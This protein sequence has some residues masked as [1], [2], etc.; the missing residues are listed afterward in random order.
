MGTGVVLALAA[1]AG[2]GGGGG[3]ERLSKSDFITKADAICT[4]AHAKEQAIDFPSVDP[5]SATN[6]Q[7]NQLADAIDKA[8]DVDRNEIS[9]L[10]DLRPPEDFDQGFGESM[11]ELSEGLDHADKAAAAARKGDKE[12]VTKELAAVEAKANEANDRARSYG[13]KVCGGTS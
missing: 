1:A 12:N 6:D 7:L 9:D 13:L 4:A 8:T 3:G 5:Q 2:C 10:R 11:N